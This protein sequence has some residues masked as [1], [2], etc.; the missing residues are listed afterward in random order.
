MFDSSGSICISESFF[1]CF[2]DFFFYFYFCSTKEMRADHPQSRADDLVPQLL[3]PARGPSE[4]AG[5]QARGQTQGSRGG[6]LH[7]TPL[8][9]MVLA[10]FCQSRSPAP[11]RP[12]AGVRREVEWAEHGLPSLRRSCSA[13][14]K[15][16]VQSLSTKHT[17]VGPAARP[18][19]GSPQQKCPGPPA[20]T[21]PRRCRP[22]TGMG[23]WGQGAVQLA[24]AGP[25]LKAP[26]TLA[27]VS[28]R[29]LVMMDGLCPHR[30]AE[31][32]AAGPILLFPQAAARPPTQGGGWGSSRKPP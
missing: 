4:T 6:G 5:T 19:H 25:P 29:G 32:L 24:G 28:L 20:A 9:Q 17:S 15:D 12:C 1:I 7:P 11:A 10:P 18:R 23:S 13:V 2:D 26:Q 14:C 30:D 21:P 22:W 8:L 3:R 16:R 27:S 31:S